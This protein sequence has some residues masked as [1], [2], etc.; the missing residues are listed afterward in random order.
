MARLDAVMDALES[1]AFEQLQR[2][3][4]PMANNDQIKR[5]HSADHIT[6]INELARQAQKDGRVFVDAD[7]VVS[8]GS[9]LAARRAAGALC[10][11]VD[12]VL[13]RKADNAFCAIRPPGH[14][15]EADRAMGFCLFNN[16]AIGAAHAVAAHGLGRVAVVDFDVHHGNGTQ[17]YAESHP[18]CL[19]VST[20]Q[21]PHY[22]G[23]GAA[24]EVGAGNILN[25]P[26]AAG[27]GSREVREAFTNQILPALREYGPEMVFISAG[28]DAHQDDPL[29]DLNFTTEDYAWMTDQLCSFAQS[30]CSGRVVS[31][32]EGGYN[33]E[34]LADSVGAHIRVLMQYAVQS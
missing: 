2:V 15:A 20:H 22:P 21:Y 1:S 24:N 33:L 14:H 5:V 6:H 10:A 31:A 34:A 28:F 4:A 9:D 13:A 7:T 19:Y 12:Q 30:Q 26:M 3:D 25:I 11:A 16:I 29:A 32:L 18:D 27:N 23:T 8:A 17:A